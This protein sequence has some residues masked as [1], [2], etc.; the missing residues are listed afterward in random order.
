MFSLTGRSLVPL[1]PC[2]EI[3]HIRGYMYICKKGADN[4][5]WC[6]RHDVVIVYTES[7]FR[8]IDIDCG[9]CACWTVTL[10]HFCLSTNLNVM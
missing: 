4:G 9:V 8:C 1:I 10:C 5:V 6:D 2:Y 7:A 3:R